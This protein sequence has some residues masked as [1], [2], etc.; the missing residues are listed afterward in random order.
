[1]RKFLNSWKSSAIMAA[2]WLVLGVLDF[3]NGTEHTAVYVA[4]VLGWTTL[5]VEEYKNQIAT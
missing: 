1:M 4:A 2:I 5:S 3:A